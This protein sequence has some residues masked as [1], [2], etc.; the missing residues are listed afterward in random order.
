VVR[1]FK[2]MGKNELQ[3]WKSLCP[4]PCLLAGWFCGL[5]NDPK[6]KIF[7]AETLSLMI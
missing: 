6:L 1:K 7:K 3:W 2:E 5:L 4:R